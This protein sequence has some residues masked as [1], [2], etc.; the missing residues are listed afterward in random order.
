MYSYNH[1]TITLDATDRITLRSPE[2]HIITDHL[3]AE[4]VTIMG[5]SMS[6]V[7]GSQMMVDTAAALSKIDELTVKMFYENG[8]MGATTMR[9]H[10]GLIAQDVEATSLSNLVKT[11]HPDTMGRK[12]V[13]MGDLQGYM[14]AAIQ[15]LSNR[16]SALES[17]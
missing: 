7:M 13:C 12:T 3:V 11:T 17:A 6:M 15:E 14:I 2:I 16:I 8:S 4:P 10:V 5:D 1:G 9:Q